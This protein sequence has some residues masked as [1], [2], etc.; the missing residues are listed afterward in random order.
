MIWPPLTYDQMLRRGGMLSTPPDALSLIPLG[1]DS[2]DVV[3]SKWQQ[4]I[5]RESYKR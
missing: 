1:S 5:T 4:F 2:A 3:E